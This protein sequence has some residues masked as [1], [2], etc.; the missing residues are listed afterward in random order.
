MFLSE[1][2][3]K[4]INIPWEECGIFYVKISGTHSNR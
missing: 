3:T 2:R 4:D 1:T